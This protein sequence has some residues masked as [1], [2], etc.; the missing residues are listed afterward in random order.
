[1]SHSLNLW[2]NAVPSAI[3]QNVAHQLENELLAELSSWIIQ[4]ADQSKP[5][6]QMDHR[7]EIYYDN[8]TVDGICRL[9][10]RVD[11]PRKR[12]RLPRFR[13]KVRP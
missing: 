10:V 1:M 2:V 5:V 3:R 11:V 7:F 13:A 6:S 4:F 12:W 9:D 8:V